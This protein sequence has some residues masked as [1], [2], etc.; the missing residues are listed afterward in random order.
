[1]YRGKIM[2]IDFHAHIYPNRIAEKAVHNNSQ[3]YNINSCCDGT[4]ETLLQIGRYAH[5]DKFVIHPVAQKP[6]QVNSIN[7]YTASQCKANP[8][9]FIGF[10]TLHID[11]SNPE[12]EICRI[13]ALGL[14]GIK[15]H[16]DYQR[17]NIDDNRMLNIFSILDN[18]LPVLI[19]AGDYR[20]G[21][22]HPSRIAHVIDCFPKLTV[23]AA[24]F[25]GW[26]LFDLALE[27]LERRFCYMDVS[28]SIMFLGRR[29]SEELIRIYGAERMIFGSDYPM[30]DP[31][32]ELERFQS[33][34]I[35]N[36]DKGL[37]LSGNALKI[38]S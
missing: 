8:D 18:R 16:P 5:I 36:G 1:M 7:K 37:I 2:I 25:G 32:V 11:I 9:H 17:F 33:L 22:S 31:A 38:L 12:E 26:S 19:H 21:Y 20:Y 14:K 3:F 24:H 23:V 34:D 4:S 35:P 28:S 29:R 27:Y 13:I 6:E 30:W 10:G 15:L